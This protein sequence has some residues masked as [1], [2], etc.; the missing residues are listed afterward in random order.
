VHL[1]VSRGQHDIA[2]DAIENPELAFSDS[3]NPDEVLEAYS[4]FLKHFERHVWTPRP[5]NNPPRTLP[6]RR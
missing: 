1:D 6:P 5:P 3:Q 2:M 4:N